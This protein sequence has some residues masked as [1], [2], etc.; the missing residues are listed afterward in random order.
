MELAIDEQL[1]LGL[2]A[3]ERIAIHLELA[4]RLPSEEDFSI[5]IGDALERRVE[6]IVEVV[7]QVPNEIR[8]D[9]FSPA[10][11]KEAYRWGQRIEHDYPMFDR[12]DLMEFINRGI[13]LIKESIDDALDR[14]PELEA[15]M[16]VRIQKL[17]R[18]PK[19]GFSR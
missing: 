19:R 5:A 13:P 17:P 14:W 6:K 12:D 7:R 15:K 3:I 1:K 16:P 11:I 8:G 18:E 4:R 2:D 9:I 10:I